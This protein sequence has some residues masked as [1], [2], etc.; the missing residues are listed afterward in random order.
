MHSSRAGGRGGAERGQRK[1]GLQG[2]GL[3][4]VW[5]QITDS[6]K[7]AELRPCSGRILHNWFKCG[8]EPWARSHTADRTQRREGICFKSCHEPVAKLGLEARSCCFP[9]ML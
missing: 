7:S 3:Q 5:A 6:E 8:L 4:E 9:T 2:C 1:R